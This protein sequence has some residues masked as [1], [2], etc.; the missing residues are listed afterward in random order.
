MAAPL[1]A[2]GQRPV[3]GAGRW[4]VGLL[5]GGLLN[6]PAILHH[7][8]PCSYRNRALPPSTLNKKEVRGEMTPRGHC[9]FRIG[10]NVR[11]LELWFLCAD[12][13]CPSQGSWGLF[14][15]AHGSWGM[16]L[17]MP[18]A[19]LSNLAPH[20]PA[21]FL[22]QKVRPDPG[23][24]D[25]TSGHGTA[26]WP[27]QPFQE[28]PP[29]VA[30]HG[31]GLAG[32][33]CTAPGQDVHHMQGPGVLAQQRPPARGGHPLQGEFCPLHAGG[34]PGCRWS[35]RGHVGWPTSRVPMCGMLCV[36]LWG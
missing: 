13:L 2:L 5:S 26:A 30:D 22:P 31:R 14:I 6:F 32:A 35:E 16:A 11:H 1:D 29:L 3:L 10:V 20:S 15:C 36:A 4:A 8:S 24:R 28:A 12:V 17:N 34:L 18:V 25:V 19:K 9:D 23:L 7:F 27:P 33:A 21:P